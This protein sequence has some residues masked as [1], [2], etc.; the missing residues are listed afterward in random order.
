LTF[1]QGEAHL[2]GKDMLT[3]KVVLEEAFNHF[4]TDNSGSI[5]REEFRKLLTVQTPGGGEPITE[6]GLA[7]MF[8][9]VSV[10]DCVWLR[11]TT[12][13][14]CVVVTAWWFISHTNPKNIKL[15]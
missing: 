5:D 4:D 8:K 9:S 12:T 2:G 13:S 10:F 15:T 7:I 14:H 11:E 6:E 3:T 1:S